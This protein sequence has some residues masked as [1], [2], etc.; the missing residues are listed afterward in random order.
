M[1]PSW[2]GDIFFGNAGQSDA[3][4]LHCSRGGEVTFKRNVDEALN[5]DFV[6]KSNADEVLS[7]NSV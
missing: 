6:W 1:G 2:H 5:D 4:S 3:I 7:V